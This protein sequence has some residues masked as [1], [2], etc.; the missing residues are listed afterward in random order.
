MILY[1]GQ[2]YRLYKIIERA[3]NT[4]IIIEPSQEKVNVAVN[5]NYCGI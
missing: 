4:I 1:I 3:E 5:N 2:V